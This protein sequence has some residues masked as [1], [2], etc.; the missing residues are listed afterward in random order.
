MGGGD[1]SPAKPDE[2]RFLYVKGIMGASETF[3]INPL[4]LL[5][6]SN[7][8]YSPPAKDFSMLSQG[9]S[10]A[11]A[12][13]GDAFSRKGSAAAKLN[14]YQQ[15]TERLQSRLNAVTVQSPV[16]GVY[17]RARMPSDPQV[18]GDGSV[19]DTTVAGL[20]SSGGPARYT[21]AR[22]LPTTDVGFGADS[23][24][25]VDNQDVKSHPG[26]IV[27]DNPALGLPMRVPTLDGDEPLH[28]Y[29]YPSVALP[30]AG[31][32]IDAASTFDP[33]MNGN[34]DGVDPERWKRRKPKPRPYER[35][36]RDGA[37]PLTRKQQRFSF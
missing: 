33:S 27:V 30:L 36:G 15:K 13:A 11:F 34:F 10:D 5:P 26:Y 16:P 32:G 37:L 25:A 7:G 8:G 1:W 21:G 28:W 24:R 31:M 17:G 20:P 35:M 19:P 14:A 3:G 12:L 18:Y 6:T 9:I 29:E 23:R 2:S 22:P 4:M